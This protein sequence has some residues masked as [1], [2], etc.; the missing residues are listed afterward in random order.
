[1]GLRRQDRSKLLAVATTLALVALA[2]L[3]AVWR[4]AGG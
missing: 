3:L 1:V 2:W 4:N